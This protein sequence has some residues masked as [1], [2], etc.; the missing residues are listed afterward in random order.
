[1]TRF[2][3]LI[4]AA[5]LACG[6][7]G[8]PGNARPGPVDSA[9]APAPGEEAP[10]TFDLTSPAFE[11]GGAI[12]V[13][14]TCDGEDASP[15]LAWSGGP[16]GVAAWALTVTDPDAPGGTFTHWVLYEIPASVAELPG[17]IAPGERADAP[18]GALQGANG[19]GNLGWG[20]PCPPR[21]SAHRYVFTLY[22]L[23]APTGLDPG[24]SRAE[25]ESALAGHVTGRAERVGTYRR[26]G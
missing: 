26:G 14:H 18:T 4:A 8:E 7:G 20:G 11:D 15:A 10:V 6:S 19:F 16:D 5:L 23:D 1:M 9:D 2:A 25:L 24:A 22:A 3:A 21:G 12:P 17:G 13:A